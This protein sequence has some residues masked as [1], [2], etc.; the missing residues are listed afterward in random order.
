M[1]PKQSP[2]EHDKAARLTLVDLVNKF[3]GT[4]Q[5]LVDQHRQRRGRPAVYYVEST[6]ERGPSRSGLSADAGE[7]EIVIYLSTSHAEEIEA[8]LASVTSVKDLLGCG[9][10]EDITVVYGSIFRRSRAWLSKV[11]SSTDFQDRLAK[12]ERAFEL[13]ALDGRQA[14]YDSQEVATVRDLI[15]SLQDISNACIRVGSILLIKYSVAGEPVVLMRNLS[16]VE[17]RALERFP[18]IQQHPE[19]AFQ[20]LAAAI[21]AMDEMSVDRRTAE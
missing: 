9:P 14:D 19:R 16:Q 20:A 5:V 18:E 4:Y 8:V 10:E 1:F 12:V 6:R 3:I 17:I 7:L 21:E 2:G 13:A 11:A 15:E